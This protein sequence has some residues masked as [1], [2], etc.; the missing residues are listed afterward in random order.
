MSTPFT[1]CDICSKEIFHGNAYVAI[2]RNIEQANIIASKDET[3]VQV[4]DSE[5]LIILCGK[6]GNAFPANLISKIIKAIPKDKSLIK[7]N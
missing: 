7:G 4:I 3:E 2:D 6:C 5:V 1:S